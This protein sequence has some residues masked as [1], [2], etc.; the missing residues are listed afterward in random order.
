MWHPY[1]QMKG[2]GQHLPVE[3]AKGSKLYLEDGRVIIDAISSWWVNP[4]GHGNEHVKQAIASQ[5]EQLDHVLFAGFTHRPAVS[6]AERLKPLLPPDLERFFYSDNGSTSVEVALKMCLQYFYNK[7]EHQRR[8]ILAFE[9]AYHGD[10]FGA[11]A[12]GGLGVFNGAFADM[13]PEV[14]RLP[15]PVEGNEDAVLDALDNIDLSSICAFI[16]EPLVQGAAGM[17]FYSANTLNTIMSTVK[18]HGVFCVADEVMTGFGRLQHL[19]ASEAMPTQPDLLCLSKALTAGVLPMGLTVA[20]DEIYQGFYSESKEKAFMHGHSFTAN[21]IGCAA[22]IAGLDL[23]NSD[24]IIEARRQLIVWQHEAAL[25]FKAN[26]KVTNVRV[27]GTLLAMDVA[28]KDR[29]YH[30]DFRDRIYAAFIDRG[31]LLRPLGNVLY[32]LP[33]YTISADEIEQ[34]YR[35]IEE[36]LEELD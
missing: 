12:A 36:V 32:V 24:E 18:K 35:S 33:P 7:G 10:T 9:D 27:N 28:A 11:M 13:L 29:G 26:D 20:S 30:N 15:V 34:V 6:L 22:A 17:R 31:V 14:K 23:L 8:V 2:F 21:P 19:F 3:R 4:Y 5:I 1:T 16:Y 25:R